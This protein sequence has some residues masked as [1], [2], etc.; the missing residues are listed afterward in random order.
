MRRSRWSVSA[1][2][3]MVAI[4]G[5]SGSDG[6]DPVDPANPADPVAAVDASADTRP[7]G[8]SEPDRT[9]GTVAVDSSPPLRVDVTVEFD[10]AD[11]GSSLRADLVGEVDPA[12]LGDSDV[13]GSFASCSGGR[14]S[15]GPYSVLVSDPEGQIESVSMFTAAPVTSPGVYDAD[16]RVELRSRA[17]ESATGTVTIGGDLRSGS[18]LAL[19]NEGGSLSGSFVCSGG[20]ATAAP[21]STDDIA[22]VL[23]S[24]EVVALLRRGSLERVVS[25]A[26]EPSRASSMVVECPSVTGES[27]EYVVRVDGDQ[28]VGALT[29]FELTAGDSATMRL[30]I[31]GQSYEFDEAVVDVDTPASA[32]TFSATSGDLT[33]DGAFRCT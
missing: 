19:G 16:I 11:G 12:A 21:L 14:A 24:V 1:L 31:G 2:A 8:S 18:F 10:P 30:R 33:V 15:F 6:A 22:G 7:S 25:L 5:C 32:G 4:V 27:G 13:F 26:V 9:A 3:G 17:S 29:T 20:D 28:S 23:D